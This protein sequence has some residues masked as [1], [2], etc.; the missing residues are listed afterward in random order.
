MNLI[1]TTST[2]RV[3][4]QLLTFFVYNYLEGNSTQVLMGKQFSKENN[5]E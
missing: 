4:D 5:R 1:D 3:Y 2:K